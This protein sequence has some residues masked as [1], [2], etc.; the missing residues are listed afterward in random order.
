MLTSSEFG[1]VALPIFRLCW[2]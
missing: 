2:G 1:N